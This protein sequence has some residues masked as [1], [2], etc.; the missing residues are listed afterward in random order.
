MDRAILLPEEMSSEIIWPPRPRRVIWRRLL[1][2]AARMSALL[3]LYV[4]S[5]GPMY[6]QWVSAKY[7]DGPPLLAAFY[8]PLWL[9][10]NRYEW[11][12][13]LLNWYVRWWIL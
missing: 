9:V 12:G 1:G 13:D 5:I 8:E 11:L 6:W 4:L 2:T 10:A 3:C 7:V